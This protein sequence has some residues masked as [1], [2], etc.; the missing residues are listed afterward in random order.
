MH[1]NY[2][3]ILL[4]FAREEYLL[5]SEWNECSKLA[6][7]AGIKIIHNIFFEIDWLLFMFHNILLHK[8]VKPLRRE[9][10]LLDTL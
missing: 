1:S 6:M 7:I 2:D 8:I 4:S 5:F 3:Y 9:K 10:L